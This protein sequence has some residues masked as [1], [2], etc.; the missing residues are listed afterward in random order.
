MPDD[1][2]GPSPWPGVFIWGPRASRPNSTNSTRWNCV[3]TRQ[4]DHPLAKRF[5]VRGAEVRGGLDG[6]P[7]KS[8]RGAT[9]STPDS[10][11]ATDE[12]A[13]RLPFSIRRAPITWGTQRAAIAERPRQAPSCA[14]SKWSLVVCAAVSTVRH[15][16]GVSDRVRIFPRILAPR[17]RGFAEQSPATNVTFCGVH[18]PRTQRPE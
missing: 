12:H 13:R 4:N 11:A 5:R 10:V 7:A 14:T 15:E 16:I 18:S 9:D 2:P 1:T 17:N 6:R 8:E 3:G